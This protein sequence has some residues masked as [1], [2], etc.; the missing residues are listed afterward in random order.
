MLS[1]CWTDSLCFQVVGKTQN[2]VKYSENDIVQGWE[3]MN[4]NCV[5]GNLKPLPPIV[6]QGLVGC[7]SY[8]L[9]IS[10]HIP[11]TGELLFTIPQTWRND[12]PATYLSWCLSWSVSQISCQINHVANIFVWFMYKSGKTNHH[13]AKLIWPRTQWSQVSRENGSWRSKT[14]LDA[15]CGTWLKPGTSRTRDA[16]AEPNS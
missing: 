4:L 11:A 13:L 6:G 2:A 5:P 7:V 16:D 1:A 9:F 10:P 14:K 15:S 8:V 3:T 12:K